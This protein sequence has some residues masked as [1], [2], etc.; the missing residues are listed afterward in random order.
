M[1]YASVAAPS[2]LAPW[3]HLE[4]RAL[5]P[6]PRGL[7]LFTRFDKGAL[8]VGDLGRCRLAGRHPCFGCV[9]VIPAQKQRFRTPPAVPALRELPEP[10]VLA[11]PIKVGSQRFGELR[12]WPRKSRPAIEAD[13]LQTPEFF[14]DVVIG[15]RLEDNGQ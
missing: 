9:D 10:G 5:L 8:R 2:P 3:Y 13:E 7:R 14:R 12:Q 15:N 4:L 1:R 11:N 6:E